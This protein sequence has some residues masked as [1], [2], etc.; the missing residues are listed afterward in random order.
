MRKKILFMTISASWVFVFYILVVDAFRHHQLGKVIASYEE[1]AT[2]SLDTASQNI[3][4]ALMSLK[5]ERGI[6]R[7]QLNSV[8]TYVNN[9][10]ELLYLLIVVVIIN[11]LI[12]LYFIRRYAYPKHKD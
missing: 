3:D 10:L 6:H 9:H 12:F 2:V 1:V 11:K 5:A 4:V 8:N 7:T